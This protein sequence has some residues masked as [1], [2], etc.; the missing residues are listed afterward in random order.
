MGKALCLELR[1]ALKLTEHAVAVEDPRKLRVRGHVRLHEKR[2]LGGIKAAG[3]IES[4][5]FVGA[6]AK[7]GGHLTHGDG[8]LVYDAVEATVFIG[9]RREVFDGADIVADGEIARGLDARKDD[10]FIV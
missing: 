7:L 3:D 9:K 1:H 8:M 5:R 2:I 10:L 6:A 4:E